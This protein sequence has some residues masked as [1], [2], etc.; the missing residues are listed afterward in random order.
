M[1][2]AF[3]RIGIL[4]AFAWT[5]SLTPPSDIKANYDAPMQ[6]TVKDE[7]GQPVKGANVEMTVTMVD[8]DHG[9]FKHAAKETAPGIYQAAATKFYMVGTWNLKVKAQKGSESA[10]K[11]FKIEVKH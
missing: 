4:A 5:I 9:E 1:R 2:S 8:M 6:V 10:S 3:S 7:T 11:D